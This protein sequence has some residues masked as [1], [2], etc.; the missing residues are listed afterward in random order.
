VI[1]SHTHESVGELR[2]S[3]LGFTV[4]FTLLVAASHHSLTAFD[5][6]EE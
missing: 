3:L 2:L 4:L 6:V 1:A 5:S